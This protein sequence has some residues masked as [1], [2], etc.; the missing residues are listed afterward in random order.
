LAGADVRSLTMSMPALRPSIAWWTRRLRSDHGQTV[1]YEHEPE[2][3]LAAAQSR[4]PES[5]IPD[6]SVSAENNVLSIFKLL[7]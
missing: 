5:P 4:V 2:Q 7:V 1:S 3:V 6:P